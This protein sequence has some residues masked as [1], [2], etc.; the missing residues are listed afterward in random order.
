MIESILNKI[1]VTALFLCI[2]NIT[3]HLYN[4]IQTVKNNTLENPLKYKLNKTSILFLAISLA[5]ILE[6][7]FMGVKL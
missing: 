6:T 1:L 4:L 7:I 3:R 2:I 5:Y